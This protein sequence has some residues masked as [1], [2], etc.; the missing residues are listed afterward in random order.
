ME[1]QPFTNV[2][3]TNLQ[4]VLYALP[5]EQLFIVADSIDLNFK[6]WMNDHFE[7]EVTQVQFLA[8]LDNRSI[9]F[10]GSQTSIAVANRLP[11]TLQKT[12]NDDD[13]TGKIIRPKSNF[14]ATDSVNGTYQVMGDLTIEIVYLG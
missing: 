8:S 7:L 2:G 4:A 14:T 3:F 6:Q 10:L 5:N 11:I 9:Q 1:K 12:G 13:K